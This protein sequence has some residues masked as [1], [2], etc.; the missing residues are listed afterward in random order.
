M[1]RKVNINGVLFIQDA[2]INRGEVTVDQT[3]VTTESVRLLHNL[4]YTQ[5]EIMKDKRLSKQQMRSVY[6]RYGIKKPKT[7]KRA[8][9]I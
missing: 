2:N 1:L 8:L 3:T 4:G 9:G 7:P 6:L 5:E